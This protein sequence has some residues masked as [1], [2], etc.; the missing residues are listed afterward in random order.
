MFE[1]VE[2]LAPDR[3]VSEIREAY[4]MESMSTARRLALTAALLRHRTAAERDNTERQFDLVDGYEQ[5]CAEVSAVLNMSPNAASYQVH[6]A[7]VLDTRLPR[8]GALLAS[9]R[10]DWRTAQLIISRT[11]LV[12]NDELIAQLDATLA[13]RLDRWGSWSRSRLVTAIDALVLNADPDA[14]RARRRKA[15]EDRHIGINA[16]L[17]GMAELYGRVN[18]TDATAFDRKLSEMA[19][20]VCGRD[21]R[22]LHQRRADALAALTQGR[23]LACQCGAPDCPVRV[24]YADAGAAQIVI[25]VVAS[26]HTLSGDSQRPGYLDGYGVIDADQVRELAANAKQR[27]LGN[28]PVSA[29]EAFRYQPCAAL[30]RAIRCRDLTCRFPGCSRPARVCDIDHTVPFNHENPAAGGLTVPGNLKCLCRQHHRLKT[31]DSGWRDQQLADGTV[32]WTSPTG[33][34]FRT[35]PGGAELFGELTNRRR[36][37]R[38]QQRARDVARQRNRNHIQRR[39]NGLQEGREREIEARKFRNHM[40]DMLFLFKGTPSTSPFCTWVNDPREPE[41]LPPDWV[42][43]EP[44]PPPLPDDPPF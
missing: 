1:A 29:A 35:T 37:T 32:I 39:I 30:E 42:P 43:T 8:V 41:E 2:D 26:T 15:E 27:L 38:A 44:D 12:D 4:R 14:A 33:K 3:L 28:D 13:D 24:E 31:F 36:R 40:R 5:T 20:G 18:A 23:T 10:I 34:T 6:Y 19:K 17:N 22:T 7:E 25:N 9:G 16:Q 11:D 21:P